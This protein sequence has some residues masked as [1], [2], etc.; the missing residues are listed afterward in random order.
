MFRYFPF[1]FPKLL[2]IFCIGISVPFCA[3][4]AA[5]TSSTDAP[6]ILVVGDSLSA[7]FRINPSDGW[8]A[9]LQK[10]LLAENFPHRVINTSISGETSSGGLNRLPKALDN[11]QPGIVLIELGANDGL[12]G[13]PLKLIRENLSKMI[14][15]TQ[16]HKARALLLGMKLPPNYGPQYT[17]EFAQ[18]F[19]E[20]A[21]QHKTGLVPFLL[22]GVATQRRLMQSD[23]LHPTAAAQGQLLD[24]VWPHL[25]PLLKE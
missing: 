1:S 8:V 18:L 6:V 4:K 22:A 23:G 15:I 25:L 14:T 16:Q 20:L 13:L 2:L 10:R 9:L 5:S 3:A 7:G 24:T 12:R 21:Q 17:H 11:Y 19:A